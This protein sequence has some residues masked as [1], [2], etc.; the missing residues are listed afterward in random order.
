ME[1]EE[2]KSN[3]N[4]LSK[5]SGK[6]TERKVEKVI[7]GNA[8]RNKRSG[9]AKVT[10]AII[11]DDANNVASY[12]LLDVII[13]ALKKTISEVATN[14]ID[15]IL[16]GETGHSSSHS[17]PGSRVNYRKYYDEPRSRERERYSSSRNRDKFDFEDIILD[18][19]GE[20][21]KVLWNMDDCIERYG[22][23]SVGDYYDLVGIAGDYTD[24]K[25]GW[26]DLRN[27]QV[28]RVRDGFL[29]KLPR[30]MPID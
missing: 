28:M 26:A 27:A 23:V 15:M 30:P 13:P 12:L 24:H 8:R 21:E 9:L 20:A 10:D 11:S 7:S 14:G 2:Y 1:I 25:Y 16:Y 17:R 6:P 18:S 3:S 4:M 22:V 19:R 29:I 5:K